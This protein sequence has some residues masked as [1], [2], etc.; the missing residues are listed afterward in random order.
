MKVKKEKKTKHCTRYGGQAVIEGVMMR[1]ES[2]M[3]TAVRTVTVPAMHVAVTEETHLRRK[4]AA[5]N[6]SAKE[7]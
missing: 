5:N 2:A 3:A 1:G 7:S 4:E 6:A